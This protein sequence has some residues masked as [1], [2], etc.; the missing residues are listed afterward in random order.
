MFVRDAL[1]MGLLAAW[2]IK[3]NFIRRNQLGLNKKSLDQ[4]HQLVL[5]E[6]K[7]IVIAALDNLA[8]LQFDKEYLRWRG[9]LIL[10]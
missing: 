7:S 3:F 1:K 5:H 6:E 2:R 9:K 8:E 4:F 10:Q